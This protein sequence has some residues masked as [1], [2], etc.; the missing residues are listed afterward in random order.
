LRGVIE[1]LLEDAE[2]GFEDFFREALAQAWQRYQDTIE[3][4]KGYDNTLREAANQQRDCK[5]FLALEGVGPLN[6]INL[7]LSLGSPE[8]G[9]FKHGRDASACIGVSPVQHSSGGKT[10]IGHVRK[11]IRNGYV[12]SCLVSG[13]MATVQ[14]LM[15]REAK[16][17]KELWV[18]QVAE[19]R[20]VRC[21]AVALANKTVRTAFAMLTNDTEYQAEALVA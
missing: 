8:M 11:E 13:A 6:A 16:T 1:G 9:S 17:K 18:Q 12:R 14:H 5:R 7:Y 10:R 19:R 3:A 4:I 2:N 20:G 21:A 15:R